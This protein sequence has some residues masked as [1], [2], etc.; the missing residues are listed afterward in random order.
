[1]IFKPRFHGICQVHGLTTEMNPG[2]TMLAFKVFDD[3][4]VIL[5]VTDFRDT[6]KP[7]Q[8]LFYHDAGARDKFTVWARYDVRDFYVFLRSV[9]DRTFDFF[10]AYR[11]KRMRIAEKE[12]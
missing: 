7:N 5:C 3:M 9:H 4:P 10:A 8:F 6:E 2:Q 1:M 12:I 11:P